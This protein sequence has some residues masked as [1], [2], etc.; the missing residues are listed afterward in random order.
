MNHNESLTDETRRVRD[1]YLRS[2]LLNAGN[3]LFSILQEF[4]VKFEKQEKQ[5]AKMQSKIRELKK[6][7]SDGEED[8][9]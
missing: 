3:I 4:E 6:E 9:E 1:M 5:I 8:P 2:G 7:T